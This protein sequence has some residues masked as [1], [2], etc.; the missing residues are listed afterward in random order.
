LAP[1]SAR[2]GSLLVKIRLEEDWKI[3][4]FGDSYR[5]YRAE[6]GVLVPFML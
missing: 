2:S 5:P 3:E 6:V 4:T 1:R